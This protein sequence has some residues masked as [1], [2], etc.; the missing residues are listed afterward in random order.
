MGNND[1]YGLDILF[2]SSPS[3]ALTPYMP[4][5]FLYLASYLE[6]HGFRVS[7]VDPHEKQVEKNYRLIRNEIKEKNPR[8]VGLAAFVT[9]YNTIVNLAKDI[10]RHSNAKIIVGNAHPSIAPHDFLYAG[11]PF[12]IVVRGEGELTLKQLL[13]EYD[14]AK[15]NS[16]I[17]GIAYL[18][19]DVVKINA[20]REVMDLNDIGMPA[21]HMLDMRWYAK[22]TKYI[23]R[24]LLCSC[25]VI[26]TGR[27]C[28]YKCG[29]CAANSVWQAND[30]TEKLGFV[31]RRP[32]EMVIKELEILQNKHHF[33]FFY[34]IDDTFGIREK[35]I[36]DFCEA[37]R[38]SGLKMLWG[39]ETRA[40]CIRNKDVVRIMKDA[41][42]IQLDFGV[43]T[44]SPKLLKIIKKGITVSQTIRA[45]SLCKSKGI[46]TFANILLNI[47]EETVDDLNLT[48]KL[49][50][51]IRPSYLTIGVTQPYPGTEFY[52][53][54]LNKPI[55]NEKY[56]LFDRQYPPEE[57]RMAKHKLNLE[58]L[59]RSW[60]LKYDLYTPVEI[61]M[62]KAN[63]NY[64]VKIILSYRKWAYLVSFFKECLISPFQIY[65][66]Y[67]RLN[68]QPG[69]KR[70]LKK[71]LPIFFGKVEGSKKN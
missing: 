2:V 51:K 61:S 38:K 56:H 31:R 12:D 30:K 46:R 20:N 17:K 35:D 59:E 25:A 10:K 62:F 39:A 29:F 14:E 65:I 11:S 71:I 45:F 52:N 36:Y 27:G 9:D 40:N 19:N 67:G 47:P 60:M 7:I 48:H 26:Y 55:S 18:E 3:N 5:Y 22:P 57:Y 50:A 58:K 64:W 24:R 1:T 13:L 4:F 21:Y 33:D 44:G 68:L 23:I 53:K 32:L 6:K 37:Y 43:E 15:D 16:H 42:C 69:I 8:Y 63:S 49:L 66:L 41:G 28:P 34:I 70:R 54:F